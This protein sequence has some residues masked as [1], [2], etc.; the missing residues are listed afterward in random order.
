MDNLLF[1]FFRVAVNQAD[2]DYQQDYDEGSGIIQYQLY[3]E[4]PGK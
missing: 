1:L 2:N 4:I 3:V